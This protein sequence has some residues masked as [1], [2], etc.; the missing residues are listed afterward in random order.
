MGVRITTVGAVGVE[1]DGR[2]LPPGALDAR[3]TRLVLV[4]L[5]LAPSGLTSHALAER[6]WPTPPATWAAALRGTVLALRAAL[7][8]I[9][10][11]GQ[12]LVRTTASGWALAPDVTVDLIEAWNAAERAEAEL[13]RGH[14]E[15]ALELADGAR[16]GGELL[17]EEDGDWLDE[18]RSRLTAVTER[19]CATVGD[20]ALALGRTAV[21]ASAARELLEANPLDERAHRL[22]IRALASSGDRAGA[23]HAFEGCRSILAE[24]LGMDPGPETAAVYLEVLRSGAS[25]GGTLPAPPRNG[26]F[27]RQDELAVIVDA[28]DGPGIVALLGRGGVGKSR[29]AL[30]AAQAAAEAVPGGRYWVSL[31]DLPSPDLVAVTVARAIGAEEGADPI[32]AAT[33]VLAPAGAVLLVL[34]GCEDV[35]DGVAET[36]AALAAASPGLRV[37]ATSRRPLDLPDERK[38]ELSPFSLPP[39][40]AELARGAAV[41]L[42]A[43]RLAARGQALALDARNAAAVRAL[44]TRCGGVPLALELAA[45]QLG[46]MAVADLLD[47]LP[48]ASRS[49]EDVVASLLGQSYRALDDREAALFRAWGAVDGALSLGMATVLSGDGTAPGRAAR[50]LGEL[51]EGGLLRVDR[52]GPRWRYRQDDQVR[53]FARARLDEHEGRSAVL[54]ALTDAVRALLPDDARTPPAGFREAVTEASDALRTV[55]E[56]AATGRLART[57]GLELAFRLHRYWTVAGLPEGRYWLGRLLRDAGE[58]PWVP[59][60]TFAAGYLAY[61]AGD[62]SAAGPL[63]ESAARRL[64]GVDDGFAAR[65]LTFAAGIADDEDRPQAAL[66]DIREAIRLAD[67]TDDANLQVTAAMGVASILGERADPD[68]IGY[69]EQALAICRDR[70]SRDQLLATLA[71][72]SMI[73][74]QVGDLDAARRWIEEGDPLL[75]EEPRI[76]RVVLTV[77][78][79]GVA[80]AEDRLESAAR[81]IELAVRDGEELGVE[82]EL[83]LA[84]ALRA[85]IALARGRDAEAVAPAIAALDTAGRLAYRYPLAIGLETAALLAGPAD[86]ADLRASAD[87]IRAAG[88]RPSPPSLR[89]DGPGGRALPAAEAAA[90]ARKVLTGRASR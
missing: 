90:L 6:I 4:A 20:A 7:E 80:A 14:A 57:T 37:L 25:G 15:S 63:L 64:R 8:P 39:D 5:A 73:A 49:A 82:R 16:P 22:L 74:F 47:A 77:A 23:I 62:T 1:R 88:D 70:A 29:L 51:A 41:Q 10:L 61:W 33:A 75:H 3:R 17:A 2:V 68:A 84:H 35:V 65:A 66:D 86:A 44:C 46:S 11:G 45:A 71:T 59:F 81:L 54:S 13:A 36:I 76:A 38:V 72:A 43:D 50:L 9:G 31:G 18:P 67:T 28:L 52:S 34:D 30:H 87:A 55:L 19:L 12:E 42:L 21:A 58:D 56:A 89:Q 83:P 24:Q 78:A 27:G 69:A 53:A 85:R 60:A 40:D 26:F 48:V 79:A 32:A